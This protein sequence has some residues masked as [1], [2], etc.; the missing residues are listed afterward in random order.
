MIDTWQTGVTSD[1][2]PLGLSSDYDLLPRTGALREVWC[3]ICGRPHE[4]VERMLA[5]GVRVLALM[6]GPCR[7]QG[8]AQLIAEA[9][10]RVDPPRVDLPRAIARY[11][12][13]SMPIRLTSKE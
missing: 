12:K 2:M 5:D 8:R 3:S 13:R 10:K 9:A 11:R 7:A 1:G 6:C 4:D